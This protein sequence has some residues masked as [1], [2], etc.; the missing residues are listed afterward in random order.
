MSLRD[1]FT[2]GARAGR[3][4]VTEQIG[5][6]H[7]HALVLLAKCDCGNVKRVLGH[8]LRSG[9]TKSCGCL[10]R[11]G[12]G[13]T[14]NHR[15]KKK[16]TPEYLSWRSMNKRCTNPN[17]VGYKY[18]GG[19]GISVCQR[20]KDSFEAFLEDMGPRPSPAHTLDRRDNEGDY[21]KE[22][23]RW[24]TRTQQSRNS[25]GTV[26]SMEKARDARK[27]FSEGMSRRDVSERLGIH[28]VSVCNIVAGRQWKEDP[29]EGL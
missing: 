11:E 9:H 7:H 23:C 16:A 17:E 10:Y 24:A 14:H 26:L 2:V 20:W 21:N 18:W 29:V 28:Y 12:N 8:N 25:R 6:N 4:V 13:K 27:L 3:L 1:E 5:M 22:N 19:R 15:A